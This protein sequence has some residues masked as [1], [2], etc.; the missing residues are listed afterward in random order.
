MNKIE[1]LLFD[2]G[3]VLV[4]LGGMG[5]MLD[6]IDHRYNAEE[7]MEVWLK[8]PSVRKFETGKSNPDEFAAEIIKEFSL[9]VETGKFLK[10]FKLW[11]TQT[12]EGA[13]ELLSSLRKRYQLIS[14][15]NSNE[16]HW[17]RVMDDLGLEKYFDHH[18]PS[19]V[20]GQMKPEHQA[21]LQIAESTNTPPERILFFD[22]SPTNIGVAKE[23]GFNAIRVLGVND[24]TAVLKESGLMDVA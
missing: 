19:H 21:F 11:P 23:L 7:V 18:F 22:D 15:S 20:T 16:V 24:I 8:S 17:P 1:I 3:G 10:E 12:F 4:E 13:I 5:T 6:W 9:P 2:I 14:L